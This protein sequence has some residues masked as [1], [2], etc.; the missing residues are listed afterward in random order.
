MAARRALRRDGF[1]PASSS[2]FVASLTRVAVEQVGVAGQARLLTVH[3]KFRT[4]TVC[5]SQKHN[6]K[7]PEFGRSPRPLIVEV[8]RH[9]SSKFGA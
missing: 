8:T 1:C 2:P 5:T 3:L 4:F 6:F 7:I 9:S